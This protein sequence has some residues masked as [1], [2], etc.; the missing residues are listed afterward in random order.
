MSEQGVKFRPQCLFPQSSG[1]VLMRVASAIN[2]KHVE[3]VRKAEEY[4]AMEGK[5]MMFSVEDVREILMSIAADCGIVVIRL[6]DPPIESDVF[7]EFWMRHI[8]WHKA[9]SVC[10]AGEGNQEAGRRE[11]VADKEAAGR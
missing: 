4:R 11:A 3:I 5:D 10:D 8:G 1:D 6:S 9:G 7:D 2:R